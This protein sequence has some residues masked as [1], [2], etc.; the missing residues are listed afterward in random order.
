MKPLIGVTPDVSVSPS[1]KARLSI[2]DVAYT[3]AIRA[4]G[5]MPVVFP[6]TADV[7]VLDPLLDSCDGL[8]L[9]GGGDMTEPHYPRPLSDTER[10]T[11]S[12]L[13]PVR[14]E[15]EIHLAKRALR[16]GVPVLGICRGIQLLNLAAG[17]SLIPDIPSA[18][19][20]AIRH[21]HSGVPPLMHPVIWEQAT[22]LGHLLGRDITEVNS[23]HHQAVDKVAPGFRVA[24]RA[25]DG[26]IEAMELEQPGDV[27][28]AGVQFHPERLLAVMPAWLRLFTSFVDSA[29]RR[30]S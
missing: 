11:L 24:A 22:N 28:V 7:A 18:R 9:T 1:T 15:M 8:L 27:F 25:P 19:P 6:L 20:D 5:G 23:T 30:S 26:I 16:D 17:G 13:D 4:A 12:G 2:C 3:E 14:D 29:R 10:G 21:R